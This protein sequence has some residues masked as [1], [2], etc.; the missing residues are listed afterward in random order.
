LKALAKNTVFHTVKIPFE[1]GYP[2]PVL[3]RQAVGNL[4]DQKT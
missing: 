1:K 4:V 2:S 3:W